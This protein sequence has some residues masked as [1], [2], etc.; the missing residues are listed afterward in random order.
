MGRSKAEIE[1]IEAV[2][3]SRPAK[4]LIAWKERVCPECGNKFI[5]Y[6]GQGSHQQFCNADHRDKFKSRCAARGKVILP[7]LMAWRV[8]R[9]KKGTVSSAAYAEVCTILDLFAD[10]DRQA[11]RPKMDDYVGSILA[12]GFTYK[13][14]HRR[15]RD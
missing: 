10:E 12:S 8:G 13:D 6:A 14:R 5:A 2:R 15:K 3:A 9:G 11:G 1:A 4:R 7:Y